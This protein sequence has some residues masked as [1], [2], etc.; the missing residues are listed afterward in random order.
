MEGR[1][2]RRQREKERGRKE[3]KKG[4]KEWTKRG[5]DGREKEKEKSRKDWTQSK[6]ETRCYKYKYYVLCVCVCVELILDVNIFVELI[7]LKYSFAQLDVWNN[8]ACCWA[9]RQDASNKL[10]NKTIELW[11]RALPK[12]RRRNWVRNRCVQHITCIY[13]ACSKTLVLRM[14]DSVALRSNVSGQGNIFGVLVPLLKI[15]AVKI[16]GI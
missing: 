16:H 3:E 5:S 14:L 2:E 13:T 11:H 9:Y 12:A 7:K 6:E 10:W 8:M 4:R 15:V 1:K